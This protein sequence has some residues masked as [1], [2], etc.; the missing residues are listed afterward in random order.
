MD[1]FTGYAVYLIV[2][3]ALF[4]DYLFEDFYNA[5]DC[6]NELADE[7]PADGKLDGED[8]T[9]ELYDCW[10]HDVLFRYP[11]SL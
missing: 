3:G 9:L 5:F 2:G 6:F 1:E 8:Y 11:R 7:L 10:R 4:E